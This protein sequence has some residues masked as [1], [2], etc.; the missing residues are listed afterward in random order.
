M[1]VFIHG[2]SGERRKLGKQAKRIAGRRRREREREG[3]RERER[4]RER[5][6]RGPWQMVDGTV[7]VEA[8]SI[9]LEAVEATVS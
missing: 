2:K 9:P 7:P 1:W 4:M 6:E 8:L 3:G 5:K